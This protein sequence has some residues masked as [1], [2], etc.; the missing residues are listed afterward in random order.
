MS[1]CVDNPGCNMV[2]LQFIGV[3]SDNWEESCHR[4]VEIYG[5][6]YLTIEQSSSSICT[7]VKKI[8]LE[9]I[10]VAFDFI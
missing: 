8:V 5:T 10:H 1:K 9:M 3:N 6:T 7:Y 2:S 4:G